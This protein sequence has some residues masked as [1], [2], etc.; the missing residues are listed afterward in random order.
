MD[1]KQF[2]EL[3]RRLAVP[4]TRGGFFKTLSAAGAS[5]LAAITGLD[6][7]EA[8][9]ARGARAEDKKKGRGAQDEGKGGKKGN[10]GGKNGKKKGHGKKDQGKKGNAGQQDNGR[11]AQNDSLVSGQAKPTCASQ[12]KTPICHCPPGNP[13]NCHVLCVGIPSV[14]CTEA[15]GDHPGDC[16]CLGTINCTPPED[17][18]PGCGSG[19][20]GA[21]PSQGDP[22]TP[23]CAATC[24]E[25]VPCPSLG[26]TCECV[27]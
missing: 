16:A 24:S 11:S 20:C 26:G 18:I 19:A 13:N 10:G 6:L 17:D 7:A 12:G 23:I 2:D 1:D 25:E 9:K 5:A 3:S 22:C 14:A 21:G 8:K 27:S 4:L 15:H